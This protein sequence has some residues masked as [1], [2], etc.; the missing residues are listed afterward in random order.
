MLH[1]WAFKRFLANRDSRLFD[2]EI[3]KHDVKRHY[4]I[5]THHPDISWPNIIY[6]FLF[7]VQ[8]EFLQW[9]NTLITFVESWPRLATT[10]RNVLR[11]PATPGLCPPQAPRL[12]LRL[13]PQHR[14]LYQRWILPP[15]PHRFLLLRRKM[16]QRNCQL[17]NR[18]NDQQALLWGLLRTLRL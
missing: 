12:R 17:L 14:C 11:A 8:M 7:A 15:D 16:S 3:C 2:P 18:L 13:P 1:W 4:A 9:E 10:Q 5:I 6:A